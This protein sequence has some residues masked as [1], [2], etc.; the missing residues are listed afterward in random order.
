MVAMNFKS[1]ST[2]PNKS[3]A[4]AQKY[5]RFEL[6]ITNLRLRE[7][8][9]NIFRCET[10]SFCSISGNLS[11]CFLNSSIN[12]NGI[13]AVRYVSLENEY[14]ET[15]GIFLF[16]TIIWNRDE[17][18]HKVFRKDSTLKIKISIS[19]ENYKTQNILNNTYHVLAQS[20]AN[21]ERTL[22]INITKNETIGIF[23]SYFCKG[24]TG[25]NC[26][27][28]CDTKQYKIECDYGT[29]IM[30]CKNSKYINPPYC[31]ST[32]Y[33]CPAG[34]F[35]CLNGGSCKKMNSTGKYI[36]DCVRGYGGDHCEYEYCEEPC[37]PDFGVC[38][39]PN[40]CFCTKDYKTGLFCNQTV[41]TNLICKNEGKCKVHKN[42]IFCIC[43]TERY[44]GRFCQYNCLSPCIF[45]FCSHWNGEAFCDC[46]D[47][48]EGGNCTVSILKHQPIIEKGHVSPRNQKFAFA[49]T[50][51]LLILFASII[52]TL[53]SYIRSNTKRNF[54]LGKKNSRAF[55]RL[56]KRKPLYAANSTRG[57][58]NHG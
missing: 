11:G 2:L 49:L 18:A 25:D 45:G 34:S 35:E 44:T 56:A 51:L 9:R 17:D 3:K 24:F 7:S 28:E 12:L 4:T 33:S 8:I 58:N 21:F 55:Q 32:D 42:E 6:L 14:D 20:P 48:Y 13:E 47:G 57:M 23:V 37:D 5:R 40:K 46:F 29:G 39:G 26:Q 1:L 15:D 27:F 52:F 54:E 50:S 43:N 16:H 10:A 31:N 36:C 22:F 19:K 41:C 53:G 30:F 38:V